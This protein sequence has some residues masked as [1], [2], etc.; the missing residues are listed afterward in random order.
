MPNTE[1]ALP[2]WS[3]MDTLCGKGGLVSGQRWSPAN[4]LE[5]QDQGLQKLQ[6]QPR[7]NNET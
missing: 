7:Y 3:A 5:H 1:A 4:I 2:Y 6:S